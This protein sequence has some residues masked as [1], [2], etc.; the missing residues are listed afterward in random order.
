MPLA[1]PS[2]LHSAANDDEGF[3]DGPVTPSTL[4]TYL[5]KVLGCDEPTRATAS[6]VSIGRRVVNIVYG[7]RTERPPLDE[8]ELTDVRRVCRVAAES[9]ARLFAASKQRS[10]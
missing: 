3:F 5:Y 2:L 1:S 6:L 4:H 9:Y 10:R 7:H 8:A